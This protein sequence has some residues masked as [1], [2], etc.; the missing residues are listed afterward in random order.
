[1]VDA[2]LAIAPLARCS[3]PAHLIALGP[4]DGLPSLAGLEMVLA[5]S[6]QSAQSPCDFLAELIFQELKQ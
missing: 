4:S 6:V 3:V 1:M 2:G 5:R